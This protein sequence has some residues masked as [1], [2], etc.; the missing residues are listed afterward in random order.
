M[1]YSQHNN[2]YKIPVSINDPNPTFINQAPNKPLMAS[3]NVELNLDVLQ[4][5]QELTGARSNIVEDISPPVFVPH[6]NPF[7]AKSGLLFRDILGRADNTQ[8]CSSCGTKK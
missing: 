7:R 3:K 2:N 1:N 8:S 4:Q 5:I 6:K